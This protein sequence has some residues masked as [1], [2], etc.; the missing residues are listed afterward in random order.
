M[1][2]L[3]GL[4]ANQLRSIEQLH[5]ALAA[6]S[7]WLDQST[8]NPHRKRMNEMSVLYFAHAEEWCIV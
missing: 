1:L 8:Y 5:H 3:L 4:H 2:S 7:H 6:E